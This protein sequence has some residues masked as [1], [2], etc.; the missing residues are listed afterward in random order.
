M[1]CKWSKNNLH[2]IMSACVCIMHSV[3]G[4][5]CMQSITQV[6]DFAR[7]I[8]HNLCI[9]WAG[10]ES[11]WL[12]RFYFWKFPSPYILISVANLMF[13]AQLCMFVSCLNK[14]TLVNLKILCLS[15]LWYFF[16]FFVHRFI[17]RRQN[18]VLLRKTKKH[19]KMCFVFLAQ[20]TAVHKH[21]F[22]AA[23]RF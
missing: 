8:R 18:S 14:V 22:Q 20:C 7:F 21:L 6:I 16:Y 4:F 23:R 11:C 3:F 9:R 15:R 2:W 13:G 5:P 17:N 12:V 10:K 19:L 1:Q